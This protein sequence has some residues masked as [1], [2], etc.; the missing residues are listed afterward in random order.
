VLLASTHALEQAVLVQ[1]IFRA[2]PDVT[3][4]ADNDKG[5][6][7]R[8]R[9]SLREKYFTCDTSMWRNRL[10]LDGNVELSSLA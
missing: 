2:R 8:A 6:L 5:S 7:Y 1:G 10:E 3:S 9:C 4:N